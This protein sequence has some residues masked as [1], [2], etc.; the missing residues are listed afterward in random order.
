MIRYLRLIFLAVLGVALLVV[1][2][3]NRAP[4][5][6]RLL[7]DDMA[8]LTGL[9]WAMELPLFLVI[10]GG[11]ILGVLIGFVWEWFREHG[12]RATASQKSREVTRLERELAVLKDS[13][14]VPPK[15]EVLAL[16]DKR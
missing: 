10:F 13:T 15:D 1:A 4:V 7:P 12:H 8:A 16:L 3:A 14:S 11:I 6:V 9:T 5:P 2:L